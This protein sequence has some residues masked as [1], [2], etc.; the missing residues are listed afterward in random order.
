MT[1]KLGYLGP[2]GSY[3]EQAAILYDLN[4][5]KIPYPSIPTVAKAV[6][7]SEVTAGLVPIENS[8]E[9]AVT[10]TLDLL[11]HDSE[12]L[13]SDEVVLPV[14]HNLL[15]SPGTQ[16]RDIKIVYSHPQAFAQ[17]RKYLEHQLPGVELIAS[18]STSAAVKR[19]PEDTNAA[20]IGNTRA[21]EIYN[22]EIIDSQIEDNSNNMTRFVL[23]SENDSHATGK[24][25]TSICFTFNDDSPGLLYK[26]MGFIE[27]KGINL[28][29]V[30]SRP[31]KLEL[32]RYFFLLDLEGHRTEPEI[33]TTLS[34]INDE[35]S[36]LKILGSYPQH[37]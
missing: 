30:E 12:L 29:K 25:K 22:A 1:Q 17:C 13:I 35:V 5:E 26:V 9:G 34:A 4:A 31:N 11:I 28:T 37:G 2:A 23:L 36:G 19:L 32:G 21:A 24:D 27:E 14:H 20:A 10:Y 8:I 18:L 6:E 3:A 7:Q 15:V 33:A 16:K